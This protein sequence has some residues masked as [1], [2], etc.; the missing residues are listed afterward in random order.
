MGSLCTQRPAR[1]IFKMQRLALHAQIL[2]FNCRTYGNVLSYRYVQICILSLLSIHTYPSMSRFISESIS[3]SIQTYIPIYPSAGLCIHTHLSIDLSIYLS[4]YLS[5]YLSIPIYLSI[6]P[7][8]HDRPYNPFLCVHLI[9]Q[10]M[11][12]SI[13]PYKS[14]YPL[15]CLCLSYRSIPTPAP[16]HR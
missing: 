6:H 12:P 16:I 7:C 4:L 9:H 3:L 2:P 5:I 8:M 15:V 14:A 1:Q 10:L 13:H 11:H